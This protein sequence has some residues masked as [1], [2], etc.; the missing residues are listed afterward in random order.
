M[1]AV[2]EK[3]VY[4]EQSGAHAAYVAADLGVAVARISGDTVGEFGLVERCT[5]R[6]VAATAN[7]VVAA[8]DDDVLR[9]A[10]DGTATGDASESDGN[11]AGTGADANDGE[12]AFESTGFGPAVAVTSAGNDVLAAGPDG[13]IARYDGDWTDGGTTDGG[14]TDGDWTELAVLGADVRALDADL[15]AAT[16]G[17]HRVTADGV[18][19][20]GL[21]D[22]RDVAAAG[23]PQAATPDALYYLG[24]GWMRALDGDFEVVASD[25]ATA[26]P[27]ELG[28]A[29]AATPD[30]LYARA[31]GDWHPSD[32]P[33]EETVA[34]VAYAPAAVVVLTESGT[35]AV[36][37][38]DGFRHRT[39]G[40]RDARSVCVAEGNA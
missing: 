29:H 8:T 15:V 14:T 30:A 10:A 40:L 2:R 21:D 11:G 38:G 35:L 33:V 34:D 25:P 31:D 17:V 32:L 28:R 5:A 39:L 23:I 24:N 3:R 20:A 19:P 9:A 27:G 16:D 12:T 18:E 13:R 6:D 36:D 1:S 7:G 26:T 37:A 22:V 4:A